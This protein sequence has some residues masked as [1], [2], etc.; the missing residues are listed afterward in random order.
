VQVIDTL[1]GEESCRACRDTREEYAEKYGS[2]IAE[3]RIV[4]A[5]T[6]EELRAE[7]ARSNGAGEVRTSGPHWLEDGKP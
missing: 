6:R 3:V 2:G 1:A 4:P 5:P 7:R